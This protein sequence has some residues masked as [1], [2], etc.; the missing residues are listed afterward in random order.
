[1]AGDAR[2][3][4][5]WRASASAAGPTRKCETISPSN[6]ER[7]ASSVASW[8]VE[9]APVVELRAA[10]EMPWMLR[11]ISSVPRAASLEFCEIS[12][13]V[14]ACSSTEEAIM[15]WIRLIRSMTPVIS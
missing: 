7:R 5:G 1:M 8:A 15:A 4:A 14:A 6:E 9:A 10:V 3:G 12:F 13:I 2:A 11:A